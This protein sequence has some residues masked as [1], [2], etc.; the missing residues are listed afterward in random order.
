MGKLL[1]YT[2]LFLAANVGLFFLFS[3]VIPQLMTD[4]DEGYGL[5]RAIAILVAMFIAFMIELVV[6]VFL[7][8]TKT[9]K[10]IGKAILLSIGIIFLFGLSVCNGFWG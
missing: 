2:I 6:A 5:D 4:K 10:D 7:I 8:N 3:L 9:R 1:L